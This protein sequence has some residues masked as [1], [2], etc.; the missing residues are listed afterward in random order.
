MS[1]PAV[2][3][4]PDLTVRQAYM[5][6][7]VVLALILFTFNLFRTMRGRPAM[8][9]ARMERSPRMAFTSTLP[10]RN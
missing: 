9:S 4:S 3:C 5:G 2:S 6:I 8:I 10:V 7:P 1:S